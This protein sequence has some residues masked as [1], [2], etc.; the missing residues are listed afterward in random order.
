ML[1]R[2]RGQT[3][4]PE[5]HGPSL[6]KE[7]QWVKAAGRPIT[8]LV[9]MP[10]NEL[11]AYFESL[12]QSLTEHEQQIA[13]RLLTEIN[14][15]L[16]FLLDVGLGYLTLNRASNSL[17]GGESQRIN[18]ATSLGSALVG[19]LYILDEPSIG[20]HPRDTE[21]LIGVLKRLRDLG[22]TVVVV[23]HDEAIMRQADYLIDIGPDAGRHGG[24]V[25]LASAVKDLTPTLSDKSLTLKYLFGELQI[26]MPKV[27]RK[28][29]NYIEIK[30]AAENNLK[31]I[32]VKFPLQVMTVVTGVSGSGKSSLVRDVLY[33]AL[34]RK[35]TGQSDKKPAYGELTGSVQLIN[36]V[37]MVDQNPIGKSSRSNP[38]TYIKAFDEI[39]KLMAEQP[40]S[41]QMGFTAA[42]FSFNV[43]G[44]RCPECK[45]EGTVTVP[46]QFMADLVLP[47][48]VCHGTR[49]KSDV[50]EV[51]YHGKNI[52]DILEMT[53][54]QAIEFFAAHTGSI[55]KRIVKRLQPLVDVG[56]GY[57][58]MG[59]SSA[60]LS[61][62]ES[63]RV[64]LASFLAHDVNER[65]LFIFDEPTTG[66]HMHDIHVLLKA[67]NALLEK[68]H[69]LIVIEHNPEMMKCADYIIDLGPD[70]GSG[71]GELVC[72]GTPEEV[73]KV[74]DA[75]T[76]EY[77][78]PYIEK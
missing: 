64:K 19:S 72:A 68:G 32:D 13:Q 9:T 77:L 22:N 15:R 18:L 21:K 35:L 34:K 61:G 11:Y 69:S 57:L 54:N 10:V 8:D 14:S 53:I 23:E 49:F 47:C 60:T 48:E 5:F 70:G 63:Q 30:G 31:Y 24:E 62:G 55:E 6:R 20:L 17:S 59:Q 45:G 52:H 27:R 2:Y 73:A 71:G 36:D 51:K 33:H 3:L 12:P 56:I 42:H 25:V 4:C 67:F 50:L 37:V 16:Q 44:G 41:K 7:A 75:F 38:V 65:V 39:R 74:K 58:Q 66:L 78:A 29:Q 28:F 1:A 46:M 43:D 76:A 26:P 40:L